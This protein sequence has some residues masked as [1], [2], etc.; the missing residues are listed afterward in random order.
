MRRASRSF[1]SI[2]GVVPE[3]MSEWNPEM[4][5]QAIVMNANGNSLP[6]STGPS[7]SVANGVRAGILSG[8]GGRRVGAAGIR[9]GEEFR[10]GG[11]E[12][13]GGGSSHPRHN[14]ATK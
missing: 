13:G 4:A 7:P 11:R 5:P 8:G 14:H 9:A 6:A 12:S 3:A 2:F 1:A 10:E